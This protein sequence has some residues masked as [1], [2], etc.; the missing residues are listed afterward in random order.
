MSAVSSP[1]KRQWTPLS[2]Y[3]TGLTSLVFFG[4]GL[5]LVIVALHFKT[6]FVFNQPMTTSQFYDR[7]MAHQF[8]LTKDTHTAMTYPWALW[9]GIGLIVVGVLIVVGIV[10]GRPRVEVA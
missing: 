6:D 5:A 1:S 10:L 4:G 3:L 2:V 7:V 9:L 8:D